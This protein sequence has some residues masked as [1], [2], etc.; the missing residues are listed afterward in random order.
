M[1]LGALLDAGLPL[2]ELK[3]ALGSLAVDG[4][5]ISATRVLRAGISATRFSLH[6]HQAPG[7]PHS[8]QRDEPGAGHPHGDH[9][10]T[11]NHSHGHDHEH[12]HATQH[13]HGHRTLAEITALIDRSALSKA[14]RDQA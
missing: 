13:A 4:Y 3:R 10:H 9:G 2:D 6:E 1:T 5:E 8:T 12:E 11:H 14:G 7:A